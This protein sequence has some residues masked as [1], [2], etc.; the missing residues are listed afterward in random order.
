MALRPIFVASLGNP[1]PAYKDTFHSAGHTVIEGL[2][3]LLFYPAFARDKSYGKGLL[4]R[5]QLFTLWQSPSL[6][7]DS[8]KL[9][10]T[11]W[12]AFLNDLPTAEERLSAKLVILHDDLE[13]QLGKVKIKA[14]GSAK[15][16]NG[17]KDCMLRLQGVEFTRIGIGIG[18]PLSRESADVAAYVLRKMKTEEKQKVYDTCGPILEAL[19]NMAES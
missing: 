2:R 12:K 18:R 7:N 17:I 10:V 9:L 19:N 5:G 14:G 11:S 4:T 13:G 3:E 1:S 15:G 16:H 6:M 8:G